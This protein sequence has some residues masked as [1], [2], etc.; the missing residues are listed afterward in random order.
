MDYKNV[1]LSKKN[2]I[3]LNN[4]ITKELKLTN[5][6]FEDKQKLISL[7]TKNMKASYSKLKL[8]NINSS[9]VEF[10]KNQFNKIVLNTTK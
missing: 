3:F 6:S 9:N 4:N 8:N 7:I 2:I 1:F 5:L 10:I